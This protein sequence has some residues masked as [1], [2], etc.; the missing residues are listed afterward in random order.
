[1][2][3]HISLP[4][5]FKDLPNLMIQP[6]PDNN[7][8]ELIGKKFSQDPNYISQQVS[9]LG[10]VAFGRAVNLRE[11]TNTEALITSR[12]VKEDDPVSLH[13]NAVEIRFLYIEQT[14]N[15]KSGDGSL[16]KEKAVMELLEPMVFKL[17][18][19]RDGLVMRYEYKH[20]VTAGAIP[21]VEGSKPVQ[22]EQVVT[23]EGTVV[24]DRILVTFDKKP[25][26]INPLGFFAKVHRTVK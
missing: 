8:L 24:G 15:K 2:A 13:D 22:V 10:A 23:F 12:N 25:Y 19:N 16:E 14:T 20:M 18:S 6:K 17:N 21:G 5:L 26:G 3:R 4:T 11:I 9:K 7:V 1:M